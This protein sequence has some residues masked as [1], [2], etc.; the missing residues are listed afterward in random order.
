MAEG[1]WGRQAREL[2]AAPP[3]EFVARRT[4]LARQARAAGQ[5]DEAQA[6]AVLRKPTTAADAVNRV[7]H[8]GHQAV[9][10]LVHL[11]TRL[12][13]AQSALDAV[14]LAALRTP[15]DEVIDAW[16]RATQE[17]SGPHTSAVQADIRDT[18]IA[19]LADAA[20]QEVVGSGALTR[21]LHYS[22]FGEVDISD[23]VARTSTGVLLTRLEGGAGSA[24]T[25]AEPTADTESTAQT[26]TPQDPE[27]APPPEPVQE[28]VVSEAELAA[29]QTDVAGAEREQARC[30][31]EVAKAGRRLGQAQRQARA[32]DTAY[33]EAVQR[34][35]DLSVEA[36]S[37]DS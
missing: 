25:Y 5:P 8:S 37:P 1:S 18:V 20:A 19:A 13:Q 2:Y 6:V 21:A 33:Q 3:A 9:Q 30:H 17:V 36:G 12:R 4:A 29:A 24:K 22:G 7:V 23:A 32:A 27:P 14:A 35:E 26:E 11:G 16:M 31:E 34:L 28:P 10:E 15:R